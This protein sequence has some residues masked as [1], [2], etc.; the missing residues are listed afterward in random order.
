MYDYLVIVPTVALKDVLLPSFASFVKSAD[1]NTLLV[2]S[3]NPIYLEEAEAV[4][5]SL[6]HI[7]ESKRALGE[8]SNNVDFKIIW[9][10]KPIG[11]AGAINKAYSVVKSEM[12]ELPEYIICS[13]DDVRM[14][15]NWQSRLC[16]HFEDPY[17][18]TRTNANLGIHQGQKFE[19]IT[20]YKNKIGIVGPMSNGVYNAQRLSKDALSV[21]EACN[22]DFDKFQSFLDSNVPRY[23]MIDPSLSGFCFAMKREVAKELEGDFAYGGFLDAD[24]FKIGGYEDDDLCVRAYDLGYISC[25]AFNS[26]VYHIGHQTLDKEFKHMKR[27]T[28]NRLQFYLKYKDVTQ[29]V[30]NV[31]AAYRVAF[32]CVNDFVQF[33]LSLTKSFDILDGASILFTNNPSEMLQSYDA[34]LFNNLQDADK[35]Y[36]E[37]C[38]NA[39]SVEKLIQYTQNWIDLVKARKDKESFLTNVDFWEG[40]FNERDERNR[41]HEMAEDLDADWIVSIDADEFFEDRIDREK[42]L[43]ILKH[44][45]PWATLGHTGWIN[46]WETTQLVRND[47]PFNHG[48]A[49]GMSG[50]RIWKV[51]KKFGFRIHAGTEIGLHCGNSPEFSTKSNFQTSIRFR[52]LSHVRAIDRFAKTRF[53]NNIDKEKNPYYVGSNDY[54]HISRQENVPVSLYNSKNGIALSMLAYSKEDPFWYTETFDALYGVVDRIVLGWT[55][56]WNESDKEWLDFSLDQVLQQNDWY[57]TGP[58]QE[59]AIIIKLYSVEI[60]NCVLTKNGGLSECRNKTFDK[61]ESENDGTLGW[62]LFL[63]PDEICKNPDYGMSI[64]R[65]AEINDCWGWSFRFENIINEGKQIANSESIRM[66]RIDGHGSMRMN[67][68]VHEGFDHALKRLTVAG[69]KTNVRMAPFNFTNMGLNKNPESLTPKLVKYR[70]LLLEELNSNPLDSGAWMALGLQFMNDGYSEKTKTCFERACMCGATA[71]MPYREMGMLMLREAKAYLMKAHSKLPKGHVSYKLSEQML[72]NIIEVCP[73]PKILKT[74]QDISEGVELPDFPYDRIGIDEF[75][76]FVILPKEED[77]DGLQD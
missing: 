9:S 23:S 77:P 62:I 71:Y 72:K 1:E 59:L 31:I 45:N 33:K 46:H 20:E 41:T 18:I 51:N 27:G 28:Q 61:I 64:R 42:L 5:A 39:D 60:I 30:G 58:S 69:V 68:R 74:A 63:D 7:F 4:V 10:D 54:S 8:I 53:Y 50:P 17:L 6:S 40:D 21:L 29:N 43:R 19:K 14:P 37:Q 47:S 67:G 52:H 3:V 76:E 48:Y 2:F 70:D 16:S 22:N 75:N 44:P 38:C 25:V 49:A 34:A 57:K 36:I 12:D 13:G 15:S 26:F 56:E 73:E 24:R 65:M 35:V 55:E 11:F 66:F 32:K